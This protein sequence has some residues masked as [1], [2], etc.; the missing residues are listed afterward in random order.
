MVDS[1]AITRAQIESRIAPP[2]YDFANNPTTAEYLDKAIGAL[3][4][5]I[6]I[7]KKQ[8]NLMNQDKNISDRT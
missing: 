6:D 8:K 4:A 1:P 7:L 2:N 5:H 3:N